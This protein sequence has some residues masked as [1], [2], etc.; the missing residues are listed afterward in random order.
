MVARTEDPVV[1]QKTLHGG[2]VGASGQSRG[3]TSGR[4][5]EEGDEARP[6]ADCVSAS[7]AADGCGLAKPV[8]RIYEHPGPNH[9]ANAGSGGRSRSL[10]HRRC[11]YR[12]LLGLCRDETSDKQ[13]G[14][15][16]P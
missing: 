9:P 6:C 13:I 10:R 1:T 5:S 16:S 3:C 12:V 4:R 2:T 7:V 15:V 14:L 8:A 11:A